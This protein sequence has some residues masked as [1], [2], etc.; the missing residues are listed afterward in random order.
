MIS[1]LWKKRYSVIDEERG[2]FVVLQQ[3]W[4]AAI[5]QLQQARS[6]TYEQARELLETEVPAARW[7]AAH[8]SAAAATAV[9]VELALHGVADASEVEAKH[10]ELTAAIDG[11]RAE[12]ASDRQQMEMRQ[13]ESHLDCEAQKC[14]DALA[15]RGHKPSQ[16]NE[17]FIWKTLWAT[18][19]GRRLQELRAA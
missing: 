2:E 14:R 8:A 16:R 12:L 11:L 1:H 3:E 17:D 10:T 9:A 7:R 13:L 5:E 4:H 18:P 19:A 6:L 15:A